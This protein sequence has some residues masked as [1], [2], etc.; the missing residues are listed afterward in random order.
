MLKEYKSPHTDEILPLR[1]QIHVLFIL[2]GIRNFRD[3]GRDVIV[4]IL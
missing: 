2:L 1:S 3:C 4:P